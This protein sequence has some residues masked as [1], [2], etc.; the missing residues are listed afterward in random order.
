MP[1]IG[2]AGNTVFDPSLCRVFAMGIIQGSLKPVN[3]QLFQPEIIGNSA[4]EASV[5]YHRPEM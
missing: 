2:E 4:F 3:T 5:L 1:D